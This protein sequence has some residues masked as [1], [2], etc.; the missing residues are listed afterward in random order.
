ME[1]NSSTA[2]KFP[3]LLLMF[4]R[5]SRWRLNASPC[6]PIRIDLLISSSFTCW[7][8]VATYYIYVGSA[9][10]ALQQFLHL[11]SC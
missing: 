7:C 2:K 3:L 4:V 6:F 11:R 5:D 10:I 1:K 9:E 8:K